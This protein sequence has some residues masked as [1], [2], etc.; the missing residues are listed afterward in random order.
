MV[1]DSCMV[2]GSLL[3]TWSMAWSGLPK[4]IEV[5]ELTNAS[6]CTPTI[7]EEALPLAKELVAALARRAAADREPVLPAPKSIATT[8]S[9]A[10]ASDKS[11]RKGAAV[12]E[13]AGSSFESRSEPVSDETQEHVGSGASLSMGPSTPNSKASD[14]D[15]AMS[16]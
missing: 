1:R 10:S 8:G 7:A 13:A 12:Q 6:D 4:L 3:G 2:Q 5:L 11:A 14:V 9:G 15:G 16:G